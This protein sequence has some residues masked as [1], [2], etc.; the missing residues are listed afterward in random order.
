V[1]EEDEGYFCPLGGA[2][3]QIGVASKCLGLGNDFF[4]L[5]F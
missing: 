5:S 2:G 3:S 4:G 1:G